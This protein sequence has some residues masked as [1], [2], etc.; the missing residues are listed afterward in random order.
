MTRFD[1]LAV[2][3]GD[4]PDPQTGALEPPIVLSS[5]YAF[6][7]AEDAA[8]RFREGVGHVYSRWRNPTVEALER[9]L[10][11][12]EGAEAAVALA[13]GMAAVHAALVSCVSA[14]DHVIASRSLYAESVRLFEE[15]LRRFGVEVTYVDATRP[16]A[17]AEARRPSTKVVYLETPSNPTLAITDLA[18]ARAAAGDATVI[19]DSTF[20][21]PYHQRPLELGADLVVHSATKFLCGHGDAVG[22]V[23]LGATEPVEAARR[24]GVRTAGAALS[25]VTAMLIGRGARTL[26]LRMRRASATAL[27]LA[28]RLDAHP[29]VERVLYP[30]LSSHPGHAVAARQ[31]RSGFGALVAFEVEGGLA[32]GARC[33]DGL[34]V[35]TRAVSLGDVRSL[36]TH[37]ASTTHASLSPA[38][39]AEAGIGEGL[40]RLS[41]GIEDVEDLWADLDHALATR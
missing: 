30:G 35:I 15:L 1:T 11:A 29:A 25:P 13:S 21:T 28:V 19:V 6:E 37:A 40:L 36:I 22:G 24:V 27:E 33:Y 39:R 2:H 9:K 31:M 18:A 38:R 3:A 41:V 23:V 26:G 16:E 4:D 10:A 7:D 14:G 8:T 17:I 32:A 12:L 5:A 34:E 20:A